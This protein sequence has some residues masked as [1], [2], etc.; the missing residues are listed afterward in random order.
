MTA[1]QG[2]WRTA[3]AELLTPDQVRRC[4]VTGGCGGEQDESHGSG[5]WAA[6]GDG[7]IRKAT[8]EAGE[9]SEASRLEDNRHNVWRREEKTPR[10]IGGW[11][12]GCDRRVAGEEQRRRA[13]G[14]GRARWHGGRPKTETTRGGTPAEQGKM[15]ASI[16][17]S[18]K[19]RQIVPTEAG[20]GDWILNCSLILSTFEDD[21]ERG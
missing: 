17:L 18:R 7:L 15:A 20:G 5:C 3:E 4:G 12:W 1:W 19:W 16:S 2:C 6:M 21:L 8:E 9:F 14:R 10:G 13:L 11:G